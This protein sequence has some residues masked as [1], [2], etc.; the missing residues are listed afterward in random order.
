MHVHDEIVALVKEKLSTI[1]ADTLHDSMI[2]RPAWWGKRVPIRAE[3]AIVK[4]YQK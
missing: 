2:E 4:E 3:A 1:A